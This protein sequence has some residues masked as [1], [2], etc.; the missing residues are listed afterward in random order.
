[1][2]TSWSART[3]RR[4]GVQ[5]VGV[6]VDVDV[7]VDDDDELEVGVG[8]EARHGGKLRL[9]L[10]HF[11]DGG[12][13]HEAVAASARHRDC[14]HRWAGDP[15]RVLDVRPEQPRQQQIVRMGDE[16][17]LIQRIAPPGDRLDFEHRTHALRTVSPRELAEW[18]FSASLGGT[19]FAFQHDLCVRRHVERYGLAPDQFH[20]PLQHS[21]SNANFIGVEPRE[22]QRT[23]EERRV[24]TDHDGDGARLPTLF[25][26]LPDGVAV[27]S[28]RK[29]C[30]EQIPLVH[31]VPVDADIVDAGLW[32][33]HDG[34]AGGDV[35]AGV[36]LMIH[37]DREFID[38][39]VVAEEYDLL[40][41]FRLDHDRIDGM[42]LPPGA[43]LDEV[44]YPAL[45]HAEPEPQPF[46]ACVHVGNEWKS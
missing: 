15:H 22:T 28:L 7:V 40:Y 9:P 43:L 12:E 33:A 5:H 11:L 8:H 4:N 20:R 3:R 17:V 31:H 25:I 36:L 32:I 1:M 2:K 37:A 26:F 13:A 35:S 46:E 23:N 16:G 44:F 21:A 24:M 34:E 30:A 27:R 42:S 45:L 19:N 29:Q 39:D 6:A 38:V 14:A 10:A 18:R 41:R